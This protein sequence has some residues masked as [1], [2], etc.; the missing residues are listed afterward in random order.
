MESNAKQFSSRIEKIFVS[1][2]SRNDVISYLMMRC[3]MFTLA[4]VYVTERCR[5]TRRLYGEGWVSKTFSG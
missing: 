3:A 4:I 1:E 5:L 2:I